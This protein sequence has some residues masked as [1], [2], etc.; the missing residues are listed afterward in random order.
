MLGL[1]GANDLTQRRILILDAMSLVDD[2]VL[3]VDLAQLTLL[4]EDCLVRRDENIE[5]VFAGLG[6]LGQ[7]VLDDIPALLLGTAHLDRADAGA[8]LA[9]F[10]DPVAKDGLGND[11]NVWSAHTAAL[12]KVGQQ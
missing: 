10:A 2:E 7:L 6:V 11:D 8:P 1:H 12:P 9:K 3:P 4:L 5:L